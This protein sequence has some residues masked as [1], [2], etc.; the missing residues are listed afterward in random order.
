MSDVRVDG[1]TRLLIGLACVVVLL[2]L[3]EPAR[4]TLVPSN[5]NDVVYTPDALARQIVEHFKPAGR[6]LE[7]CAGGGAFVR[8]MPGCD[9]FE[10]ALGTD[11]LEQ[12]GQWDWVV[13]NPPWSKLRAFLQ[14]SMEVADNV[15]FLCLVNA[16]FMRARYADIQAAGFGI[17]EVLVVDQPP[18]PWPQT[19]FLLGAVH[20]QR[21]WTGPTQFSR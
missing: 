11:F 14:H 20:L 6:V 18:K 2:A 10:L 9:A 4:R 8:A 21:G 16:V 17:K 12:S 15:V 3:A 19:G 1:W 13:T 7:P 5:G